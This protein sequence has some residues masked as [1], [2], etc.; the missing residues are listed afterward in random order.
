[1]RLGIKSGCGIK[2]WAFSQVVWLLDST[3]TE[4]VNGLHSGGELRQIVVRND[5]ISLSDIAPERGGGWGGVLVSK[6][7]V[8]VSIP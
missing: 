4:Q 5:K 6:G 1:M 3:Q 2:A 7:G 8:L